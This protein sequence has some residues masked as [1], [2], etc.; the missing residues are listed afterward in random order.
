MALTTNAEDLKLF[1]KQFQRDEKIMS[2]YEYI[3][4]LLTKSIFSCCLFI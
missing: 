4:P 3:E 2:I 1:S